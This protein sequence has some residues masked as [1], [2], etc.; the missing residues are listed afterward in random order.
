VDGAR[1][2]QLL[3]KA[4]SRASLV[5]AEWAGAAQLIEL[6]GAA[7]EGLTLLLAY[8]PFD[9]RPA[10]QAFRKRHLAEFKGEPTLSVV[11]GW[12]AAQ[13]A[14]TALRSRRMGE[15]V[16]QAILRIGTFHGLQQDVVMDAF[17][18]ARRDAVVSQVRNGG[19]GAAE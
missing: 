18:D 13:V 17:G 10:Y 3:R 12:D 11:L 2:A 5:A 14:F 8:D 16:K 1:F 15:T 9:A 19:F 4:G 6:G 7:V